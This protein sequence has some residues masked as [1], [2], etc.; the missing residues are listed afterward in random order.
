MPLMCVVVFAASRAASRP[1][2]PRAAGHR[3]AG[4][5]LLQTATADVDART[6]A[7]ADSH[8][9]HAGTLRRV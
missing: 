2:L 1:H 8:V 4:R 3:A 6:A 7:A 9:W 5:V